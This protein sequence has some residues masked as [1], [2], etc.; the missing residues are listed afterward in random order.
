MIRHLEASA[1]DDTA[2]ITHTCAFDQLI[3]RFPEWLKPETG[4][5]KGMAKL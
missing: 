4:V 1:I 2:C 5:I 3:E